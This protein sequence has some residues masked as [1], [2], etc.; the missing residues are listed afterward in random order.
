MPIAAVPMP[1]PSAEILPV[2]VSLTRDQVLRSMGIL[3]DRLVKKRLLRHVDEAV[4][5]V[6]GHARP[7]LVWRLGSVQATPEIRGKAKRLDR[8][9]AAADHVAIV[10]ATAG[11]EMDALVSDEP[12]PMK[13]YVLSVT[14]TALARAALEYAEDQLNRRFPN[15]TTGKPQSPGNAGIPLRLQGVV[16]NLLPVGSIGIVYDEELKLMAPLA[17]ITSIIGL[18]AYERQDGEGCRTCPS[19]NCPIRLHENPALSRLTNSKPTNQP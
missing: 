14:S 15:C 19:L 17:S 12:D 11:R 6:A 2:P 16:I 10:A 18:G 7:Q 9:L 13:K 1:I 3:S 8:Y 4:N 5:R